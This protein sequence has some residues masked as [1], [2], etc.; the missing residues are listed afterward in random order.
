MLT[1]ELNK[2]L[3]ID[4]ETVPVKPAFNELSP[5]LQEIWTE[6]ANRVDPEVPADELFFKRGGIYSEFGKII[7]ISVGIFIRNNEENNLQIK[8]KSFSGNDEKNLL[9]SFAKMLNQFYPNPSAFFFCGH[10]IKEFDIPYISRRMLINRIQLPQSLRLHEK[11]PWEVNH[12]DTMQLWRFG[13]YKNFTSLKLLTEL[14]EIPTPK[15]DIDGSKVAEV[16]WNEKNLARIVNYCN[17]DVAATAQ[18]YLALSGFP[19]IQPENVIYAD[20]K[21]PE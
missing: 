5:A 18:L 15:D 8:I 9:S 6:K 20:E 1:P 11:K 10:N 13:D 3:V 12:I 14:F 19:L 7:C 17:K 4:V 21:N 2:I 16:Y